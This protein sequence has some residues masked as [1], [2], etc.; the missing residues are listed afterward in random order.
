[1]RE[2]NPFAGTD[3]CALIVRV[4]TLTGSEEDI[5]I[6]MAWKAPP[7]GVH[8]PLVAKMPDAGN[9]RRREAAFKAKSRFVRSLTVMGQNPSHVRSAAG[10]PSPVDA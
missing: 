10:F 3:Q 6:M 7:D 1:M 8:S 2:R 5:L 4:S 9:A